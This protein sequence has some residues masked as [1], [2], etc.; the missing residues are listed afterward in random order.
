M[1]QKLICFSENHAAFRGF[2]AE[3]AFAVFFDF[4]AFGSALFDRLRERGL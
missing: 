3:Y 2:S 4:V 1:L